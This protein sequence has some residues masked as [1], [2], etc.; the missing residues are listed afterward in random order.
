[1][2]STGVPSSKTAGVA[3]RRAGVRH[4]ARPARQNDARPD[5]CAR[6]C[7]ERRV[8]RHDLGVD[9]QLTQ[10][11][12]DQL[13]VLRAEIQNENGLMGHGQGIGWRAARYR[14]YYIVVRAC[15]NHDILRCRSLPCA[16]LTLSGQPSKPQARAVRRA[17]SSGGSRA[18]RYAAIAR[19]APAADR[20]GAR[21]RSARTPSRRRV[22]G[23]QRRDA[24]LG[25]RS[26]ALTRRRRSWWTAPIE[27]RSWRRS[28]SSGGVFVAA[29]TR[30]SRARRRPA[31]RLWTIADAGTRPRARCGRGTR[32]WRLLTNP[33]E[34]D[35]RCVVDRVKSRGGSWRDRRLRRM[36][37]AT[38]AVVCCRRPMAASSRCALATGDRSGSAGCPDA[39]R[40]AVGETACLSVRPTTSF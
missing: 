37:A 10:T 15:A 28:S 12:R 9:R 31:R 33:I 26:S 17:A 1:M 8:E 22:D 18:G 21:L 11:P 32:W 20:R 24:E 38:R 29:A 34:L 4:A 27:T 2:P 30:R 6:S 36:D 3:L 13:R 14:C 16:S 39:Q 7:L 25:D 23:E 19:S 40:A 35:R 5:S